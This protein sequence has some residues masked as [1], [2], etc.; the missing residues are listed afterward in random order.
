MRLSC[1]AEHLHARNVFKPDEGLAINLS[2]LFIIL[3]I[4]KRIISTYVDVYVQYTSYHRKFRMG[5]C[6][7][8]TLL[9][10]AVCVAPDPVA[11]LPGTSLT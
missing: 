3:K 8:T 6:G 1:T 10:L 5:D 11:D 4:Y 2:P 7:I 9:P